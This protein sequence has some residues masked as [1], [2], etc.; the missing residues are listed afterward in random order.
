MIVRVIV[1]ILVL[2]LLPVTTSVGA[3]GAG[4]LAAPAIER[5]ATTAEASVGDR[6]SSAETVSARRCLRGALTGYPCTP[7]LGLPVRFEASGGFGCAPSGRDAGATVL[8][9]LSPSCPHGPPRAR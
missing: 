1:W 8:A 6:T 9:G 3:R 5:V 2:A 4:S 7:D